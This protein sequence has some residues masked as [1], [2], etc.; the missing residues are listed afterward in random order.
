MSIELIKTLANAYLMALAAEPNGLPS[1]HLYALV[2]MPSG[3]S[4]EKHNAAVAA[5]KR[6]GLVAE[7]HFLLIWT[8]PE[9]LRRKV[10]ALMNDKPGQG[11]H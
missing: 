9:E 8:G 2:A 3:G 1:G 7:S 10:A 11:T 6:L 4:L 5:V